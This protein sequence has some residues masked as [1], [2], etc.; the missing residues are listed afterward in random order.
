MNTTIHNPLKWEGAVDIAET[1]SLCLL[2]LSKP[3]QVCTYLEP[4]VCTHENVL[5]HSDRKSTT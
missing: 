1:L 3:L 4:N 5:K 2:L